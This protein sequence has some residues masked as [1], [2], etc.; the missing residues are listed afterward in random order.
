M[1]VDHNL[2]N[3][4]KTKINTNAKI[5]DRLTYLDLYEDDDWHHY[6]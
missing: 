4:Y 3:H 6:T 2:D 5:F 1:Y